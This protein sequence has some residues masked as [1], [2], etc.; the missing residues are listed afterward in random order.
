MQAKLP[1]LPWECPTLGKSNAVTLSNC[2]WSRA[3]ISFI[4]QLFLFSRTVLSA[5]PGMTS[6]HQISLDFALFTVKGITY[7][8][9]AK[10]PI[11]SILE[12]M[13]FDVS[14]RDTP[15]PPMTE[16]STQQPMMNPLPLLDEQ[17]KDSVTHHGAK[18]HGSWHVVVSAFEFLC[19]TEPICFWAAPTLIGPSH[20]KM[21]V[22]RLALATGKKIKKWHS[23]KCLGELQVVQNHPP[24]DFGPGEGPILIAV[25]VLKD[26]SLHFYDKTNNWH[27]IIYI[28]IYYYILLLC[29]R[30]RLKK[31]L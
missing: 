6:N 2:F 26:I 29:I 30:P 20:P 25:F 13:A 28:Y 23:A 3:H 11:R 18:L 9:P 4:W 14:W 7:L 8:G 1:K 19:S 15:H 31:L 21:V 27:I 24:M 5:S 17:R 16:V 12:E 22:D 10:A